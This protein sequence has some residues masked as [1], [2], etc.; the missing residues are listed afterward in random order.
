VV[1]AVGSWLAQ[2]IYT[3][4]A[5]IRV[6]AAPN[7]LADR[8]D[9]QYT[10]RIM[11]TYTIVARS[12]PVLERVIA[13][14]DL[15]MRANQLN[16]I[17]EVVAIEETELIRI[18]VNHSDPG[19][20][21]A[22]AN[23]LANAL[24]AN[25]DS[26]ITGET[27]ASE[28]IRAQMDQVQQELADMRAE[29]DRL[30]VES[31]GETAQIAELGRA[32]IIKQQTYETLLAQYDET[33]LSEAMRVNS[34]S[35][36]EPALEPLQPTMPRKTLNVA[37]GGVLGLLGG[38]GLALLLNNLDRRVYTPSQVQTV[39][40]LPILAEIQTAPKSQIKLPNMTPAA[41][42]AY[43]R[44]R[45]NIFA[46]QKD[47]AL[48]I[49]MITSADAGEGKSTIVANLAMSI[50]QL[51]RSVLVIDCDMRKPRQHE[52]F[53][54]PNSVGL[55]TVL[56]KKVSVSE[57]LQS[58]THHNLQVLTSGPIPNDPTELLTLSYMRD[59]L[60][61]LAL[62]FDFVLLDTP[63]FIPVIDAAVL[64]PMAD[65]VLQVIRSG[66]SREDAIQA[67]HSQ[68]AEMQARLIGVVMNDMPKVAA[69]YYHSIPG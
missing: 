11:N 56:Q 46:L 6:S 16:D 38:T 52:L 69:S 49:V 62:K 66:Q 7:P 31:P 33:R 54:L 27:S 9:F 55:S 21:A 48:K 24:I 65:G 60:Q 17:I 36:V 39:V 68:I 47:D 28:A 3:A 29:Y 64:A 19:M 20:A 57:A 18:S 37:L 2:P 23:S 53:E 42:E 59:L 15:S 25:T 10:E 5:M 44:L 32:T 26:N 12:T 4:T 45:V 58:T 50:A 67:T 1:A 13:E 51:G 43:R 8:A 22:I 61:E 41:R 35:L 40:D 34:I 63:A 30:L 14:L